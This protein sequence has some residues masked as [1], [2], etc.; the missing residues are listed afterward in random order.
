MFRRERLYDTRPCDRPVRASQ[1]VRRFR[2]IVKRDCEP[3]FRLLS[4]LT[5][6]LIGFHVDREAVAFLVEHGR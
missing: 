4:G 2:R 1:G 3:G 6:S 5:R